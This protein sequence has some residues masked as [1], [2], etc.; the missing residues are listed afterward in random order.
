MDLQFLIT[1]Y[2]YQYKLKFYCIGHFFMI[3]EE[4]LEIKLS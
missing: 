3:Q 4:Y 2:K 1:L